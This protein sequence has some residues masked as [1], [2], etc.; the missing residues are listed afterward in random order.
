MKGPWQSFG[1]VLQHQKSRANT[2]VTLKNKTGKSYHSYQK[3]RHPRIIN[4]DL[5]AQNTIEGI[6]GHCVAI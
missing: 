4:F 1:K 3:D 6:I 5:A 2:I